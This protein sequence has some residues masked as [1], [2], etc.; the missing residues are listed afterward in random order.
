M[1]LAVWGF[2]KRVP[3]RPRLRGHSF[4]RRYRQ[5]ARRWHNCCCSFHPEP[6]SSVSSCLLNHS[7]SQSGHIAPHAPS[8][9]NILV[10]H[11]NV[12]CVCLQIFW[13][14]HDC[15]LNG[16]LVAE[17]L[18]GPFSY[19]TDFLDRCNTVVGNQNLQ[20]RCQRPGSVE[21]LTRAYRTNDGMSFT[22]LGGAFSNLLPPMK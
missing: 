4:A 7:E 10:C 8:Y 12:V 11:S 13:S 17:S 3:S 15:E 20:N 2:L 16:A 21:H 19:G 9:L 5:S 18:V 6:V 14:G 1:T 22:L